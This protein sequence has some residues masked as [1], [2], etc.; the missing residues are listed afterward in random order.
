MHFHFK[1]KRSCWCLSIAKTLR[2]NCEDDFIDIYAGKYLL[3]FLIRFLQIIA[4][5]NELHN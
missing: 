1:D 4:V 3:Y 5:V 2:E